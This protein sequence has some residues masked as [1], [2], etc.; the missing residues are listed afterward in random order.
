[1]SASLLEEYE[2]R[3]L[4]KREITDATCEK[5]GYGVG[6]YGG[7]PVQV[8]PYRTR[9]GALVAQ[10]LRFPDKSFSW[11][12]EPK[13]AGLFG[14]HLWRDGGRKIVITEGEID[15][16]SVS[17]LQSN[18]WPV[19]SVPNGA[20]GA[21]KSIQKSLEWLELFE[22]VIFMFDTDEEGRAAAKECAALLSPGRAKIATLPLKDANEMLVAGRGS[23]VIDAIW[24]AKSYR[25]D[26][27]ITGED[28]WAYLT[29]EEPQSSIL[30]PH[31]GLNGKTRGMRGGELVTFA[32]GTGSGKST[33]CK[34]VAY[35]A[36]SAG[37]RVG[38]IALE[39]PVKRSAQGLLSIALNKPLHLDPNAVDSATLRAEFEKLCDKVAFYDHF[40]SLESDNLL[41]RI[42]YM[43]RGLGCSLIFLDHLSIVVSGID[44]DDERKAIDVVMTRLAS[45]AQETGAVIVLVVH[46]NRGEGKPHEEGRPVAMRDLRGSGGIAQL[47]HTIIAIERNQQD[48]ETRH[49]S[50]VRVLKCRWTG[51][52][53]VA[54][55]MRYDR[56]TGRLTETDMGLELATAEEGSF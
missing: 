30:F 52:T 35:A 36:I 51:D 11:V 48:E 24:G 20:G 21:K 12:G 41:S 46:L 5:F 3:G 34:E 47:S 42:R 54:G 13:Q 56:D 16:L 19:V 23:E 43:I 44:T 6:R 45:L 14:E 31:G 17:Q 8:A 22:E 29:K 25:P 50:T 26:G 37:E 27:I 49:L 1:V 10:K 39:E 18:K 2:V 9:N 15:A 40:G 55:Y 53:G 32:A 38:Y 28:V 33:L 7:R 4:P